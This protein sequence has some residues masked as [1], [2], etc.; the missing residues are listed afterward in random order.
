MRFEG[1]GTVVSSC[2]IYTFKGTPLVLSILIENLSGPPG[3]LPIIQIRL[4]LIQMGL[5][6]KPCKEASL[7]D[8]V[9]LKDLLVRQPGNLFR[10]LDLLQPTGAVVF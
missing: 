1:K 9:L 10:L 5:R 7:F 4:Y 3:G 2:G 6:P 8:L